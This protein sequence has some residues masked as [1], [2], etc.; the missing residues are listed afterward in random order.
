MYLLFCIASYWLTLKRN[1]KRLFLNG[2]PLEP[3]YMDLDDERV[4]SGV[5]G[6]SEGKF[7]WPTLIKLAEDDHIAI[8]YISKRLF[9]MI[10]KNKL[11]AETWLK[12]RGI[13]AA[14]VPEER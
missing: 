7:F 8:L 11:S 13:I 5:P 10:P 2:N 4:L 6:S 9:L 14:H 1:W 12:F 3:V